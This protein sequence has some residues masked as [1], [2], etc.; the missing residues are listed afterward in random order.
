MA[1]EIKGDVIMLYVY[2]EDATDYRPIGCLTSNTLQETRNVV[3]AQHK[4]NPGKT[5]RGYG[6]YS[7]NI[8]LEGFYVDSTSTNGDQT[9]ASHD[10]LKTF[11]RQAKVVSW[12]MD[13]GIDGKAFFGSAILSDLSMV[14]P[15]GDEY[16]TFS[17]SLQGDDEILEVDPKKK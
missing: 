12:K 1:E 5:Q 15:T 6:S 14:A 3:E 7:Y 17:G 16:A 13:T 8:S 4:C 11:I 10:F 2:D 9:V